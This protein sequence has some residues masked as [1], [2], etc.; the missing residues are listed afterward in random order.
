[1]TIGQYTEFLNK[2]AKTDTYG[3]YNTNLA[4]NQNIGGI[5]RTGSSG[6][7]VY[8]ANSGAAN[9]PVTYVSWGDAARFA[10]W[11]QNNQPTGAQGP[12]TTETGAYALNGAI[13][14]AALNLVTRSLT[15]AIV[16]PSEDEWYKAAYY[17]ATTGSYYNYPTSSNTCPR[18]PCPAPR[19]TPET[20]SKMRELPLL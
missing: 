14:D 10:N 8:T 12:L 9:L 7:Y 19:Q 16:I 18:R 1:M 2:V 3:L 6:S 13:T 15:A 20:S 11:M 5:T 4:T 17:D